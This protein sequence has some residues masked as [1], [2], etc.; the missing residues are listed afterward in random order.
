MIKNIDQTGI[1]EGVSTY[2]TGLAEVITR[3]KESMK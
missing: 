1:I 3:E 2:K